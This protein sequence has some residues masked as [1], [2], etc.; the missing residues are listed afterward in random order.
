[1]AAQR[2]VQVLDGEGEFH[3]EELGA[4]IRDS[5]IADSRTNYQVV[6]IMGPQSS[7]KSTLMNYLVR[8]LFGSAW[9]CVQGGAESNQ[10][11]FVHLAALSTNHHP[12]PQTKQQNSSAP[13]SRRWTR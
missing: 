8:L 11:A 5:G 9:V 2:A 4:F 10:T 1:M 6:A 7:G 13:A 12:A 3:G